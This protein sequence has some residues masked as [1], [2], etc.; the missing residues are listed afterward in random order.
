MTTKSMLV[1][2]SMTVFF[3]Y[4]WGDAAA[5][6]GITCYGTVDTAVVYASNQ[7]GASNTYLRTGNLA[8]S[9]LGFRGVE[10]LGNGSAGAVPAGKRL[11]RQY[12]AMKRPAS[13]ST[14]RPMS[15]SPIPASAH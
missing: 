4:P 9:K 5:Q 10:D 12:R 2:A 3:G 6:S 1:L 15:A 8:A 13:C 7:N 14:A 11:R